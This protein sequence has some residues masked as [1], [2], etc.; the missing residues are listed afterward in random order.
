MFDRRVV[1]EKIGGMH[2]GFPGQYLD[3]ESGLWYN[4]HRHYDPA[5][6]RYI[7]SD[8]I[9]LAG[10]TNTYAYVNGDPI[11]NADPMGL[12]NC[13]NVLNDALVLNNDVG[14][15]VKGTKGGERGYP[16]CS[17]FVHDVLKN[18]DVAPTRHWWPGSSNISAGAWADPMAVIPYFPVVRT[19][20]PGDIVAIAYRTQD[21]SG[22]VAIVVE[23]GKTSIGASAKFGTRISGWPWDRT[24]SPQGTPVYRR[25]TCG[26]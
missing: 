20:Q 6:G 18:T 13:S 24:M 11:S 10:G 5:I 4:W 7:Q 25:C 9:G 1:V 19:P 16:K 22:H 26:T 14:C 17:G 23:P 3:D 2:V 21:A 15:S 12:C 8:P